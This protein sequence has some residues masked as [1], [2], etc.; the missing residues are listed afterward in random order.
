MP[1]GVHVEDGLQVEVEFDHPFP[2]SIPPVKAFE[3]DPKK[4]SAT[5]PLTASDS[6]TS[7][8]RAA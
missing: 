8:A 2:P 1:I 5:N 7:I 6:H 3:F 4:V